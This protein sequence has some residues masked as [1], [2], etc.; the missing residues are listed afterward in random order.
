MSAFSYV[1][2]AIAAFFAISWTL[3]V[4]TRPDYRLKSTLVTLMFWWLSLLISVFDGMSA[5]HLIWFFPIALIIPSLV[6]LALLRNLRSSFLAV[7]LLSACGLGPVL[8]LVSNK[9]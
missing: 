7:L 2:I 1:L 9:I 3:G 8:Y 5:F 4:V 6:M